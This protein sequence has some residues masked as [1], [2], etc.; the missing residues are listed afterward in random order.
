MCSQSAGDGQPASLFSSLWDGHTT[1]MGTRI[2][3]MLGE[4]AHYVGGL[5]KGRWM[6]DSMLGQHIHG[7]T[8][9]G[10]SQLC[11]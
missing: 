10:H 7:D 3:K 4:N 1:P 6:H 2:T 11:E 9:F 5:Q 8:L